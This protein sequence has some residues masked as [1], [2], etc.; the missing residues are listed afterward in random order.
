MKKLLIPVVWLII[1]VAL[2]SCGG[3]SPSSKT[4]G[5]SYR[6]FVSDAVGNAGLFIVNASD[7]EHP[8][9][10]P[11]ISAGQTPGM[12]VVTPNRAQTLVFSGN[13][14]QSSDNQFS[15][16]NNSSESNAAHLT[17]PG[18]TQSFVVSPDSSITY[19]AVPNAPNVGGQ[20]Q[21]AIELVALNSGGFAGEIFIPSVQY[22]A[23]DNGG[24]RLLAF[25]R[26]PDTT[27]SPCSSA[28]P[29]FLFVVIPSNMGTNNA[30]VTPVPSVNNNNNYSLDHPVTAFF[31]SDDTVAYV[32]NCGPECGG[33]QASVQPFNMSTNTPG[34][35]L[36]VPAASEALVS[37]STMYVAGTPYAKGSPS[38]PCTG[39]TTA[40]TTCGLLT[41]VNL[42]TL[43]VANSAPIVITDGYH[44]R[45][46]MGDN[47]QL[48]IGAR[49]CTEI[50]P[51]T[52]P[53]PPGTEVRGCLSIYNTQ[54]TAVGNVQP[55][56]VVIPPENGD[57]TGLQPIET[58]S[59][60][61]VVQ[62]YPT[63][64]GSL[65]IYCTIIDNNYSCPT[66]DALQ[67]APSNE[68]SYAPLMVGNFYDVKTVDF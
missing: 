45:I 36:F 44:S 63:P 17:L 61:Y 51:P 14:T 6:A 8:L 58:R 12:M 5:I 1:T 37:G 24:D 29:C 59:V 39:E 20:S 67:T 16:I 41:I 38:Q 60:V 15:I 47:G 22:L 31:S 33:T 48:F 34:T 7:D 55:G 49:T 32:L 46:A 10:L 62:G 66:T 3:S 64:G 4:S 52:T 54:T 11:P 43:T 53:P 68:P 19:I 40:A 57:V 50:I 27:D 35:P 26:D 23:I 9:G 30:V 25:S 42:S 21:G 18:Y 65:Y 13:N 2:F 56:A 28:A